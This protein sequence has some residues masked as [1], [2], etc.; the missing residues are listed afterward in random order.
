MFE[1]L[2][3]TLDDAMKKASDNDLSL[4]WAYRHHDP[5][6]DDYSLVKKWLETQDEKAKTALK[7]KMLLNPTLK[8]LLTWEGGL[9]PTHDNL[10]GAIRKGNSDVV[11]YL[12]VGGAII[13]CN[14]MGKYGYC[15]IFD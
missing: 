4:D 11:R 9:N 14:S 6:K 8:N 10:M 13:H 15:Q 2:P 5:S 1:H 12:I 7:E 3:M